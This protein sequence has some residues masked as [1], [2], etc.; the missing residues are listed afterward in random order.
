MQVW[1]MH[2]PSKAEAQ[3]HL[4]QWNHRFHPNTVLYSVHELQW[5]EANTGNLWKSE[6]SSWKTTQTTNKKGIK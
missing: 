3:V 5:A 1:T 2:S 6:Y 4:C